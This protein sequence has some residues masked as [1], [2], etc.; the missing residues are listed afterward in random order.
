MRRVPSAQHRF[1]PE[2]SSVADARRFVRSWLTD[3]NAADLEFAAAQALSEL[4]TN[5][6]IHA[7]TDFVVVIDWN[8]DVLRLCVEDRSPK[9]PVARSYAPDAATGR[10]LALVSTLSR[11][12]GVDERAGGKTVW[13]EIT[14]D[15]GHVV[16]EPDLEAF[17][18]IDDALADV[19]PR[20]SGETLSS[21]A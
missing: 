19:T 20:R 10:G 11:A 8:R 2:P 18:D 13:C 4:A 14:P 1:S 17:F 7:K 15:A 21:A 6:V 16:G 12:W 3:W 9:L 5:A